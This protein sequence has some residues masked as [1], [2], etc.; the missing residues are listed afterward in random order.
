M[1]GEREI[2]QLYL[3]RE[4]HH[5]WLTNWP[6]GEEKRREEKMLP[7]GK[8]I[9]IIVEGFGVEKWRDS[10]LCWT[11][12]RKRRGRG[13]GGFSPRVQGGGFRSRS[14]SP[15]LVFFRV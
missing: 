7:K 11:W 5:N 10:S 1:I 2:Q 4:R 13:R 8:E 12:G 6:S 14:Q 15:D 9:K 3:A